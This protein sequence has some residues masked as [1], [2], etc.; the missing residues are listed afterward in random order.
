MTFLELCQRLRQEVGAAGNGP[1]NV[2]GQSGE[3]ARLIGWIRTA[4]EEIQLERDDW[5]FNWAEGSVDVDAAFR[6]FSPPSDFA[7]WNNKTLR[8][9]S[10]GLRELPWPVFRERYREDSGRTRPSIITI[11]PRGDFKLDTTPNDNEQITFEY[12]RTPQALEINEDEPRLPAR[13]RMVIVYR[14]MQHYAFY[15]N[16][17]EVMTAGRE[18]ERR[19]MRDIMRTQLPTI[20]L[21]GPLA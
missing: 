11:T 16:A 5:A 10:D 15:E 13:Y 7:S 8:L 12:W 4:W 19:L 17:Q 18:A 21:G 14:A 2:S 6:E 3:Y 20:T 1:A 9:T